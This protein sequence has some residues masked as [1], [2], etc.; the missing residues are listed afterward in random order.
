MC[1][2]WKSL[3]TLLMVCN[4]LSS[5]SRKLIEGIVQFTL[6]SQNELSKCEM[7]KTIGTYFSLHSSGIKQLNTILNISQLIQNVSVGETCLF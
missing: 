3:M 2:L 6:G 5:A 4:I 1:C 7:K